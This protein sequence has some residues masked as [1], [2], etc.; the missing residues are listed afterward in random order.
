MTVYAFVSNLFHYVIHFAQKG[1]AKSD[2][3]RFILY[4]F[5]LH[6]AVMPP[7]QLVLMKPPRGVVTKRSDVATDK[8]VTDILTTC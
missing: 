6:T 1:A 7:E 4:R 3:P 5:T 8:L 2:F